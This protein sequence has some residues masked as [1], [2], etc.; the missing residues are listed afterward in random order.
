VRV[1]LG[2]SDV[3]VMLWTRSV[4]L[5][6]RDQNLFKSIVTG[7]VILFQF[8]WQHVPAIANGSFCVVG[9][10]N[11]SVSDRTPDTETSERS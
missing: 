3:R 5:H 1:R 7:Y 8:R 4:Y 11:S 9:F 6:L 10:Y 2:R